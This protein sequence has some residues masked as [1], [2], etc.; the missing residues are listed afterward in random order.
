MLGLPVPE[1]VRD[2]GGLGRDADGEE[3]EQRGDEV[4]PRVNRL[5][6]EPEAVGRQADDELEHEQ[7]RRRRDRDQR[8]PSLRSHGAG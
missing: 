8:G 4:G 3:R 2:V 6:D 5:R 1:L 7:R